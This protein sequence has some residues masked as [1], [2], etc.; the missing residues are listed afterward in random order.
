[1]RGGYSEVSDEPEEVPSLDETAVIDAMSMTDEAV[2]APLTS[3]D[4][5]DPDEL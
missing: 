5:E 2:V 4:Q 3:E 1:M